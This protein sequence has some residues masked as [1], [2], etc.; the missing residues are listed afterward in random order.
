MLARPPVP[1]SLG[2]VTLALLALGC[3]S[4]SEPE[5]LPDGA[6]FPMDAGMD[7]RVGR[8]P[9]PGDGG[10]AY[11][12]YVDPGCDGGRSTR[13]E[14]ECDPLDPASC[15]AGLACFAF[16]QPPLEPCGEEVFVSQCLAPGPGEQGDD[17]LGHRDCAA[18]HLCVVTGAGTQCVRACDVG[19]GEPSC[20]RG[21]L[22]RSTDVPGYGACF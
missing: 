17:C 1:R 18:A 20:P 4:S 19:G 7:A 8:P 14:Y 21:F 5:T 22:C 12:V 9:G 13:T 16:A 15:A 3:P 6:P 2:P 10:F 11:D